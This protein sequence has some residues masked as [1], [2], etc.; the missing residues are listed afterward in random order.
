MDLCMSCFGA[1]AAGIGSGHFLK[2]K[3]FWDCWFCLLLYFTTVI[4]ISGSTNPFTGRTL[5]VLVLVI[6]VCTLDRIVPLKG[7]C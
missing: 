7:E 4:H 1:S 2:L 6:D 3:F 5:D